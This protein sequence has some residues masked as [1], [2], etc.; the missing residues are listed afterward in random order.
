MA[1][2]EAEAEPLPLPP[3]P[4]LPPTATDTN[5]LEQR[6]RAAMAEKSSKKPDKTYLANYKKF[7]KFCEETCNCSEPPYVTRAN[8]DLYFA[9]VVQ[10]KVE[11]N[12]ATAS[13]IVPS[14]QWFADNEEYWDADTRFVVASQCTKKALDQHLEN[15][16]QRQ[17]NGMSIEDPHQNLPTDVLGEDEI[18]NFL[19]TAM[20]HQRWHDLLVAWN[21]GENAFLRGDSCRKLRLCDLNLDNA[22]GP[23]QRGG[24]GP[25]DKFMLSFILRSYIHKDRAKEKRV[26]GVWRNTNYLRCGAFSVA[27]SC[28]YRLSTSVAAPDVLHFRKPSDPKQTPE[29]QKIPLLQHWAPTKRGLSQQVAD[30]EATYKNGG[31]RAWN[32]CTHIRKQGTERASCSGLLE[33]E[34]GSL[35]KHTTEKLAQCYVTE[36]NPDVLLVMSGHKK[37]ETYFVPRTMLMLPTDFSFTSLPLAADYSF[38][39][40]DLVKCLWPKIGTWKEQLNSATGDGDYVSSGCASVNFVYGTLPW[41]AMVLFQDGIY[42]IEEFPDHPATKKLLH[43]LPNWYPDWAIKARAECDEMI[44]TREQCQINAFNAAA[45]ASFDA[46]KSQLHGME[47]RVEERV[48]RSIQGLG[49]GTAPL[50]ARYD[51]SEDRL[52]ERVLRGI[53]EWGVTF[54]P[55]HGTATASPPAMHSPGVALSPSVAS[56]PSP[57][58]LSLV[59]PGPPVPE[60]PANFPKTARDLLEQYILYNLESFRSHSKKNWSNAVKMRIGRWQKVY[61]AIVA[62]AATYRPRREEEMPQENRLYRAAVELDRDRASMSLSDYREKVLAKD[63][64]QTRKK[65]KPEAASAV[66]SPNRQRTEGL[67]YPMQAP[68]AIPLNGTGPAGYAM[69]PQNWPNAPVY[70]NNGSTVG[71]QAH[72]RTQMGLL[73]RIAAE[74]TQLPEIPDGPPT[75]E[76]VEQYRNRYW[77]VPHELG[78]VI[79]YHP[80]QQ[81]FAPM[82]EGWKGPSIAEREYDV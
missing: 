35:T 30:F 82:Q 5:G 49:V 68:Y 8:V 75:N 14:L 16:R 28:F 65:R 60:F 67:A 9:E 6:T 51:E 72:Q 15:Y 55:R 2:A 64:K 73:E 29:W 66:R 33:S 76:M 41:M 71:Q 61:D 62:K 11:V 56:R 34:I 37:G 19:R 47:D 10:H 46:L 69:L 63:T 25:L 36:L 53:K 23:K 78:N 45:R 81:S 44:Q 22:H 77:S 18:Y 52:V 26:T 74:R 4:P 21:L 27:V 20:A 50:N 24:T 70:A 12:S 40:Q 80:P 48:L 1:D 31:V 54:A 58:H 79:P 7:V 38:S 3:P 32:K 42:L 43:V 39:E 13:R 17:M 57:A 59:P